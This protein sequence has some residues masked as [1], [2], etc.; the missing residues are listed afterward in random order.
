MT[1]P[2]M[3]SFQSIAQNLLLETGA[4]RVMFPAESPADRISRNPAPNLK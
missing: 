1:N 3:T 4:S 2:E